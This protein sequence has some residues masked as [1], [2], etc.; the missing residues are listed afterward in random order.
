MCHPPAR[1]RGGRTPAGMRA[2]AEDRLWSAI[3]GPSRR[4]VLDR[5]VRDAESTASSLA[6]QVPF[7]RQ[8]VTK[9]LAVLEQAGL[10][11]RRKRGR[12]VRYR[13]DPRRLDDAT[14]ATS[15]LARGLGPPARH[16]QAPRRSRVRRDPRAR[17]RR[18]PAVIASTPAVP[19]SG[20]RSRPGLLAVPEPAREPC[21][22]AGEEPSAGLAVCLPPRVGGDEAP[23]AAERDAVPAG[24]RPARVDEAPPSTVRSAAIRE[25]GP[26]REIGAQRDD[27]IR[28][29]RSIGV[30]PKT[31]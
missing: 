3:A 15:Q 21:P 27:E 6:G 5:L 11:N 28:R 10:I 8:A 26:S 30:A 4:R 9:H 12:E 24:D 14:R 16:H 13:V 25:V 17:R 23:P 31:R 22:T 29:G 1:H 20:R 2:E 19:Q 18:R 7:S